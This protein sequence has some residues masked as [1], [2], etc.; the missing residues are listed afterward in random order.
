MAGLDGAE[1]GR[2]GPLNSEVVLGALHRAKESS[3]GADSPAVPGQQKVVDVTAA[4]AWIGKGWR[5]VAPLNGS[6]VVI[7]APEA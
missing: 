6:K 5:F 1:V 2:L 4:E 7:Q 3:A